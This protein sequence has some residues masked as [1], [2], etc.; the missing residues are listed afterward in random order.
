[1]GC[2]A[3]SLGSTRRT[4]VSASYDFDLL[5]VGSGP[6]G[7]R[8]AVQGAKFGRRTAIVE[9]GRILGGVCL[10]TGTIPSKTFREAVLATLAGGRGDAHLGHVP[11]RRPTIE[12]LFSRVSDV[13]RREC[14]V[15]HRQ[16]ERNDVA[17]L[18]G[19]ATFQDPHSVLVEFENSRQTVTAEHILIAVGTEPAAPPGVPA[20][21]EVILTSDDVL[22]LKRLPK[23]LAVVG[24]GVIGLEYA[25][26]FSA[27]GVS[28]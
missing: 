6:A 17:V 1:T 26:M 20:D 8:A 28:I 13:V 27:L 7:Q 18:R 15:I 14:D 9:K 4:A 11:E 12:Q 10:D 5:C 25:S 21:G 3:I 22:S 16:L 24:G 2:A 23:T 19:R